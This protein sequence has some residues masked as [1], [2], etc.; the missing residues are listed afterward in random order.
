M[1][2]R[3]SKLN[4]VLSIE[5]PDNNNYICK[6]P[7]NSFI[8]EKS[9]NTKIPNI[10]NSIFE[11]LFPTIISNKSKE[12]FINEIRDKSMNIIHNNYNNND[13]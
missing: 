9:C 1:I 10:F 11:D 2:Y 6:E 7:N 3:K 4:N 12:S 13:L 5:K 8:N